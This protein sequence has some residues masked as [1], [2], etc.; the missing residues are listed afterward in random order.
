[1]KGNQEILVASDRSKAY[2]KHF[3]SSYLNFF[4]VFGEIDAKFEP[5]CVNICFQII[6]FDESINFLQ[7]KAKIEFY[8]ISTVC[9]YFLYIG[10]NL[11]R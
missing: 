6:R 3:V 8:C 1:M 5:K 7:L 4:R 2:Y 9:K 10:T 11:K